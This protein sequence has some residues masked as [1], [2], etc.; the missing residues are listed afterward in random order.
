GADW[1]AAHT[2]GEDGAVL[3]RPDGFVAWRAA[4]RCADPEAELAAVLRQVL[5][6]D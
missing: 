5:C 4:G 6:L 1:A 3:V 2:T